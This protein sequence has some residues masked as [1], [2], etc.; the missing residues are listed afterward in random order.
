METVRNELPVVS[1][2]VQL[3]RVAYRLHPLTWIVL[4]GMAICLIL[5]AVPG[6]Y[7][8]RY[9]DEHLTPWQNRCNQ[10]ESEVVGRHQN[11]PGASGHIFGIRWEHGWPW[12]CGS[13]VQIS[14]TMPDGT[15]YRP[16]TDAVI[17]LKAWFEH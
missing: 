3:W 6:D 5:I 13:R 2:P 11:M 7:S 10:L 1:W 12:N 14:K 9:S 4:V 16:R 17:H 8:Y 15:A